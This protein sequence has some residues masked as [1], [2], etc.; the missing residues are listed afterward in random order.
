MSGYVSCVNFIDGTALFRWST[1]T[2]KESMSRFHV[3]EMSPVN[4]NQ[5][6]RKLNYSV[7]F[8]SSHI[9]ICEVG[10]NSGTYCCPVDVNEMCFI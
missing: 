6:T 8:K 3:K 5:I 10:Y 2:V 7:F 9:E 4:R 1:N